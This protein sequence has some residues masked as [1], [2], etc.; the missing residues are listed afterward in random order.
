MFSG[1]RTGVDLRIVMLYIVD[2]YLVE[3]GSKNILQNST[4]PYLFNVWS[5]V[6]DREIG[7]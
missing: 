6:I 5:F 4:A 3:L 2:N 7:F 1:G